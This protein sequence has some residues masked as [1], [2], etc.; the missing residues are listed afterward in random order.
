[1][2]ITIA[3]PADIRFVLNRLNENG[4]AAYVVGG[5]VRDALLG[6]EPNDWDV[7]TSALPEEICAIFPEFEKIEI[8]KQHGT[9]AVILNREPVEIT[10][11]RIES[12][13]K[14]H[15]HPSSVSFTG[16]LTKDLSR[17]DFTINAMAYHPEHGLVDCFGGVDDLKKAVIRTVG[18]PNLRFDEDGLRILRGIRFAAQ[19][20]FTIAP[21][22]QAAMI[23]Q[24]HL[25]QVI[26]KE[27]I[28]S[29]LSK[30]LCAKHCVPVLRENAEIVFEIMP[31][32]RPMQ[33]FQ[34][35]TP[36]HCYDVW[37]HTLHAM[38]HIAPD[39]TLRLTMLLHDS[40]KP[41]T[42]M[43]DE[44]GVGHFPQHAKT[45]VVFAEEILTR[46]RFDKKTADQVSL[47]VQHHDIVMLPEEKWIKRQLNRF[48]A[49]TF[50]QLID[51]HRSDTLAQ[52]E[53]CLPRLQVMDD[54]E[55]IARE[56]LS[57]DQCFQLRDLTVNGSDLIALGVPKGK[58]IGVYLNR[59]LEA[60]IDG[61]LP[62]E[63]EALLTQVKTWL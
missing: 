44:N 51:I 10:T 43:E 61:T 4:F 54:C 35:N 40:G 60:V 55:K 9:I 36:Y 47:L 26:S 25:L 59:L 62:N 5:C 30:A 17:R 22:T 27:R 49:E 52:S 21:E 37:E 14:D 34:Q 42:Y 6:K 12:D 33:G 31:E 15:R 7:T 41:H 18:D 57:Q 56:I 16:D 50:L 23:K 63:K 29:E 20:G 8:G 58:Q 48:G 45:S 3:V 24:K 13:Y 46:L 39:L 19:L 1:M 11:Y 28:Q 32:L 2:A 53:R 38:E